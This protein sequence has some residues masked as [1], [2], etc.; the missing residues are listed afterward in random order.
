[1]SRSLITSPTVVEQGQPGH[2]GTSFTRGTGSLDNKGPFS[3]TVQHLSIDAAYPFG[4]HG[5]AMHMRPPV[6]ISATHILRGLPTVGN[7]GAVEA[8]ADNTGLM[9][10]LGAQLN[11]LLVFAEVGPSLHNICCIS[12]HAESPLAVANG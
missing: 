5:P 4:R 7:E 8:Y 12:Q 3:S 6:L 11:A 10:E 2:S 9:W 1:M